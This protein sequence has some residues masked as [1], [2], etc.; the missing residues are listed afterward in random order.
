VS[1]SV[2]VKKERRKIIQKITAGTKVKKIAIRCF[3]N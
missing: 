3:K 2:S 1:E